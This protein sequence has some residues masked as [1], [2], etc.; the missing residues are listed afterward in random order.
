M[1]FR[2]LVVC[3]ANVCRSP[4][5][6]AQL[7]AQLDFTETGRMVSIESAG[8]DAV[9][10]QLACAEMARLAEAHGLPTGPLREHRSRRLTLDQ[11]TVAD[12]IVTSD[13]RVRSAVLTM[14]P[15]G[16]PLAAPH[17]FTVREAAALAERVGPQVRGASVEECLWSCVASMHA[18]RGL[19]ELPR[20]RHLVL[21]PVAWRPLAVHDHDIPDAH[22]HDL[23]PHRI[24]DRIAVGATRQLS[25]GLSA[26]AMARTG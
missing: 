18:S 23:A 4:L 8:L 21:L 16:A 15:L 1:T 3:S 2:I 5:V 12:L 25:R 19:T 10:G 11:L 14:A 17:V 9:C 22:Q 6:A 20:T 7:A 24:V 13:R 26:G